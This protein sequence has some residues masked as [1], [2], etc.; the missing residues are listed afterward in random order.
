MT[1][2]ELLNHLYHVK[3]N[4]GGAKQLY[5]KAKIQHPKIT[6]K[7]VDKWLKDQASYQLNKEDVKQKQFLPIYSDI[8]N[9]YQIDLTFFPRYKKENKGYWFYLLLL[10]LILDM[11]MHIMERIKKNKP[12]QIC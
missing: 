4:Y 2:D 12:Y 1:D 7:I 3:K 6:F 10:I 11:H 9:N 8:P 5:D